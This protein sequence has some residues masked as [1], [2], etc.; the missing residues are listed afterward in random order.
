LLRGIKSKLKQKRGLFYDGY[1]MPGG[2]PLLKNTDSLSNMSLGLAIMQ[3]TQASADDKYLILVKNIADRLISWQKKNPKGAVPFNENNQDTFLMVDLTALAF[4]DMLYE[5]S[6][7]AKYQVARDKTS[8]HAFSLLP[9]GIKDQFGETAFLTVGPESLDLAGIDPIATQNLIESNS[10][11]Q[12]DFTD[13]DG[14]KITLK[15]SSFSF[16]EETEINPISAY[17]TAE[18][19]L[20]CGVMRMYCA[21]KQLAEK[22]EDYENKRLLY[23]R[24]LSDMIIV[25][26]DESGEEAGYLPDI[27]SPELYRGEMDHSQLSGIASFPASAYTL[28]AYYVYNPYIL[29][30]LPSGMV[31]AAGGMLPTDVGWE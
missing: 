21:E 3:Y 11:V 18:M 1:N 23:L 24:T 14:N 29:D 6:A 22:A 31:R 28:F 7:E 12:E 9:K 26:Q 16:E 27:F 2:K 5:I 20:I 17:K 10:F 4:F 25:G 19:A 13:S 15:G 8:E 30:E